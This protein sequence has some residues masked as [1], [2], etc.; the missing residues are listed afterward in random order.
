MNTGN[1]IVAF[2]K[3][4]DAKNIKAVLARQG[5]HVT[6]ACTS[7]SHALQAM[8]S[9]DG[10]VVVCGYR[11]NDMVYTELNEWLPRNFKM[12]L[13]ASEMHWGE[14]ELSDVVYV[15]MPL[16]VSLL[17]DALNMVIE[18]Q[19]NHRRHN[20]SKPRVRSHEEDEAILKAKRLLM[21]NNNMTEEEAHRYVQKCSMDSGNSLV[22]TAAMIMSVYG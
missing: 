20:N 22:E 10:G 7:G 3:I 1:I 12:L 11:L 9:L 17:T 4:E 16:K 13:V 5:F 18:T 6:A 2:P 19:L 8:E 21:E 14:R 15:P